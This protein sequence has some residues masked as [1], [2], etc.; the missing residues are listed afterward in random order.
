MNPINQPA[1]HPLISTDVR[2]FAD[3]LYARYEGDNFIEDTELFIGFLH[4]PATY[5]ENVVDDQIYE[6]FGHV[7]G[8]LDE[9][10]KL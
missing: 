3:R 10:W 2:N 7:F 4:D 8:A 1:K 5:Y 9:I 6:I